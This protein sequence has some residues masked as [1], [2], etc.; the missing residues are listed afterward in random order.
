EHFSSA[1]FIRT[2]RVRLPCGVEQLF[3]V[4]PAKAPFGLERKMKS[5]Q[6]HVSRKPDDWKKRL[7]LAE[8]FHL[9]GDWDKAVVEWRQLLAVRPN[10]PAVLKLGDTLLKMGGIETA[11]DLFRTVRRQDFQSAA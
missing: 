1:A 10:L 5:L 3:H 4:F 6:S 7:E 2:V 8:L 11:A 9:T